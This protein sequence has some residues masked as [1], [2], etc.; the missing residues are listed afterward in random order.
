MIER[1]VIEALH[2][3]QA[4]KDPKTIAQAEALASVLKAVKLDGFQD[5]PLPQAE[6]LVA[7]QRFSQEARE[8]LEKQEYVIYELTGQ[9]IKS[10]REAGRPFWSTWHKDYPDFEQLASRRSE[11]AINPNELF[12]PDSNNKTL[13]QQEKIVRDFSKKLTRKVK[14]VEGIVGEAPDY[15]ESVFAHLDATGVRLF[16]KDYDFRYTRTKTPTVGSD[17][18]S[19][20]DFAADDGLNV[21]NWNRDNGNSNVWV[22]PLV[23]SGK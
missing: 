1:G 19:V 12:L 10:L 23:V 16:G 21:N 11:V 6:T 18:A 22:S 15:V 7:V 8:T 4:S 13:A 9:S 2:R 14:G 5:V 20:G 3:A 17:V